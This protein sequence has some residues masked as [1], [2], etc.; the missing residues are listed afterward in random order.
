MRR[1]WAWGARSGRAGAYAAIR[2]ATKGI[3][4]DRCGVATAHAGLASWSWRLP[5]PDR[6]RPAGTSRA[7]DG[8][9]SVLIITDAGTCDR[10]YRYGMRIAGGQFYYDGGMG[11]VLSGQVTP[12]GNVRVVLRQG[13]AVA[14]GSGRL[15]KS[16]RIRP[17]ARGVA[18]PAMLG[19]L[20]SRAPADRRASTRSRLPVVSR[21]IQPR[22][23]AWS[24]LTLLR[25]GRIAQQRPGE[26][27]SAL[28]QSRRAEP[29]IRGQHSVARQIG[30]RDARDRLAVRQ[31]H[32]TLRPSYGGRPP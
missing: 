28:G 7:F 22:A 29:M 26:P 15:S 25:R 16:A 8:S 10:T 9:W 21:A 20:A 6:R 5:H 24:I 18:E 3:R 30:D 19:S 12:K 1:S 32:A 4:D 23:Q 2:R 31:R 13:D 11:V 27:V 17:M 14:Q